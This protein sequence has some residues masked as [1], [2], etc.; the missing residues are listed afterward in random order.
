SST[1]PSDRGQAA[2]GNLYNAARTHPSKLFIASAFKGF[3][4]SLASWGSGRVMNQDCG[5]TWLTSF[6]DIGSRLVGAPA[7]YGVQVV[8]WN[9]YDEGTE[10]ETGIDNCVGITATPTTGGVQWSVTGDEGTW[11]HYSVYISTDGQN[12][13][14]VADVPTGTSR[15][16][17]RI[18][19]I[20]PG[21]YT[22]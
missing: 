14:L 3:N 6:A 18:S 9:D 15:W 19:G 10:I 13:Q 21:S 20:I 12:L 2:L 17:L 4:D 7:P 22:V 1:N 8:T 16:D 5:R 11:D